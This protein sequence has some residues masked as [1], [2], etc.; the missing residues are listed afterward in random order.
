MAG[1]GGQAQTRSISRS[2]THHRSTCA[3]LIHLHRP[4]VHLRHGLHLN[5]VAMAVVFPFPVDIG[6]EVLRDIVG[7]VVCV[8]HLHNRSEGRGQCG[9]EI[10]PLC[11]YPEVSTKSHQIV[12]AVLSYNLM[13][14]L[15][16]VHLVSCGGRRKEKLG[17]ELAAEK[18]S[19]SQD[20]LGVKSL[21]PGQ[22]PFR[23]Q[24]PESSWLCGLERHHG[25]K[26][27]HGQF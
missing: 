23:P 2:P 10:L 14:V 26:G 9:E 1:W 20:I 25:T 17:L 4:V 22:L 18:S 7:E 12:H 5:V 16:S 27:K 11:P 19:R 13:H 24:G 21:G 15:V 3:I 6:G 8:L